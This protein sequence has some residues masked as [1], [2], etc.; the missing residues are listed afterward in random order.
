MSSF[1]IT[2]TN[3]MLGLGGFIFDLPADKA[4]YFVLETTV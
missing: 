1:K 3:F 2:N 4:D